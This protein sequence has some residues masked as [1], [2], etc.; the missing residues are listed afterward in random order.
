MG[1]S[2]TSGTPVPFDFELDGVSFVAAGGVQVLELSEL[3]LRGE[4]DPSSAAGTAAL[5]VV[6]RNALGKQEYERFRKHCREHGTDGDVL[7]EIVRDMSE[8]AASTPTTPSGQSS[9][10]RLTT[11]G[12]STED[13]RETLPLSMEEIRRWRAANADTPSPE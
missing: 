12:T 6:F 8:H 7:L 13:S 9:S 3:A 1:R 10:G 5:A 4:E 2:Y 11:G